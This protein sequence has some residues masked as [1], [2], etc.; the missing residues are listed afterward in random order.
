MK[1]GHKMR[2][3]QVATSLVV[4]SLVAAIIISRRRR[5]LHE[6]RIVVASTRVARAYIADLISLVRLSFPES[7]EAIDDGTDVLESL[8]GFHEVDDCEWLLS[9]ADERVVGMAMVVAW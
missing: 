2:T 6:G 1:K 7:A 9:F 4:A 3:L 5:K 8:C